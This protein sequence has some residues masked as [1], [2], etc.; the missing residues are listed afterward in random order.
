ME[1][2]IHHVD[3]QALADRGLL[4]ITLSNEDVCRLIDEGCYRKVAI[5]RVNGLNEAFCVTQNAVHGVESWAFD[6]SPELV[7][8]LVHMR[9]A[10]RV[11]PGLRSSMVGDI[12][13]ANGL[14][15]MVDN[16]GFRDI[17]P[18]ASVFP[19]KAA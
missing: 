18:E 12:F 4:P 19:E 3:M 2:G 1:I 15:Y 10:R 5:V 13:T 11:K 8:V 9:A 16:V 17:G 14:V 7:S 6:Q